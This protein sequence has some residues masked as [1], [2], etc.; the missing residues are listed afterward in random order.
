VNYPHE[1]RTMDFYGSMIE[2]CGICG[3]KRDTPAANEECP[4]A[5]T[6]AQ[7]AMF[8]PGPIQAAA[9]M[10]PGITFVKIPVEATDPITVMQSLTI[11]SARETVAKLEGELAMWRV[12]L[13]AVE[14][15]EKR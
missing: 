9:E 3:C 5:K 4:V 14:A 11:E 10:K 6:K 12:L 15:R 1:F 8:T 2:A 7:A 13:A